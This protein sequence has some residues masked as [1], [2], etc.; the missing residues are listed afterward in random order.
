MRATAS[1]WANGADRAPCWGS[2]ASQPASAST[3]I[4]SGSPTRA[5]T[6]SSSG[7]CSKITT[8]LPAQPA[9]PPATGAAPAP[10]RAR[11]R[12]SSPARHLALGLAALLLAAGGEALVRQHD[13]TLLSP[14]LYLL[15]IAVF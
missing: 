5:T 1:C 13:P 2:C 3:A 8:M 11:L 15:A 7:K 12:I 14:V 9:A 6:A 10:A 4:R